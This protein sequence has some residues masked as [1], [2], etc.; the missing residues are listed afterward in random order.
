[1]LSSSTI[2]SRLTHSPCEGKEGSLRLYRQMTAV[3]QMDA[4]PM[5][6][7]DDLIDQLRMAKYITTLRG[8]TGR[9]W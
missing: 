4:Y 3:M 7:I 5:P 2:K 9:C 6:R 8:A 1:M